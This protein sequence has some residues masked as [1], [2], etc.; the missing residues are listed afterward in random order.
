[1]QTDD[2]LMAAFQAGDRQAFET[3]FERF[4]APVWAYFRRRGVQADRAEEL[5]HDV[6]VAVLQA[7]RRY[8]ARGAFR[9]YL[10]GVAFRVLGAARR[11]TRQTG[12]ETS[13]TA[14]PEPAGPGADRETVLWVRQALAALD[15]DDREVLMLREY[16]Q[17][18]YDEAAAV[19]G[20]PINTVRSRLFRA[21]M[22]LR[23][24]L[25]GQNPE[26]G[27]R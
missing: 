2:E 12:G 26:G 9:S 23:R 24:R 27:E 15:E 1:V 22:A 8:E 20:V 7:A 17:L 16:E 21:R 6:F 19:L 3:L 14:A 13:V 11:A 5:T 10:F 4:R 18:R 25:E